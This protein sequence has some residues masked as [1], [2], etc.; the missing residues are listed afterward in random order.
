M[1]RTTFASNF[2]VA[3][4]KVRKN[5]LSPIN[6]TITLNG[7]KASLSTHKQVRPENWDQNAQRVI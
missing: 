1:E 2:W 5:G 4:S 3:P 7:E 6:L